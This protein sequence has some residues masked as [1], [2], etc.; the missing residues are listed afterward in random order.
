MLQHARQVL[1]ALVDGL[2][3]ERLQ[4]RVAVEA[5]QLCDA[6]GLRRSLF[7]VVLL[8]GSHRSLFSSFHACSL[9]VSTIE[10]ESNFNFF[11]NLNLT[12]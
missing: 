8:R 6:F 2:R 11:I 10:N 9:V 5:L 4:L 7:I 12:L 3:E 1:K